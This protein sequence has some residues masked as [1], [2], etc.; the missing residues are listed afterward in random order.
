MRRNVMLTPPPKSTDSVSFRGS[1]TGTLFSLTLGTDLPPS[2]MTPLAF[3]RNRES[4][5]VT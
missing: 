3:L 2:T 5:M 1:G 4:F